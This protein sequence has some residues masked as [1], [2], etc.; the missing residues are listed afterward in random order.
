MVQSLLQAGDRTARIIDELLMLASVRREDIV[1]APL[2]M[3]QIVRD[4]ES[5]LAR[6]IASSGAELIRPR[7]WPLALGHA[8]WVEEVWA[9]Y[10]SNAIKYGGR[11]PHV[12]LGAARE[13]G[14]VRFWV[15]DNGDGLSPDDQ[16]RLFREFTR[17]ADI[18]VEGHG[19]GL[20][21]VKRIVEKL[22]GTVG[23][24][25]AGVPGQGCTFSFTLPAGQKSKR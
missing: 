5:Q 10:I 11:P 24:E 2:D 9:N 13:D 7:R 12:E 17:L 19:L 3:A 14:Q 20:S 6:L 15:R 25:S 4:A 16:A 21:I 18:R 23:V 1:P 8:P 22:G